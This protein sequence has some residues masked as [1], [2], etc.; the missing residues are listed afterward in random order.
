[1]SVNI[2]AEMQYY[3]G[4][5]YVIGERY[6]NG[7]AALQLYLRDGEPLAKATINIPDI[8]LG[9][10]DVIIKN[11][12]ENEG[13]LQTLLDNKL[14]EPTNDTAFSIADGGSYDVYRIIQP[15]RFE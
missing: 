11:Y 12:S 2:N 15:E 5:A 14:I 3:K 6:Q 13:M 10:F 8:Q 7:N 1:M 4:P 9:R